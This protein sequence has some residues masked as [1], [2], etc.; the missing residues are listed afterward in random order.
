M[1]TG[2]PLPAGGE[3]GPSGD[4][5]DSCLGTRGGTKRQAQSNA[6]SPREEGGALTS[7]NKDRGQVSFPLPGSRPLHTG[8]VGAT[9]HPALLRARGLRAAGIQ[10]AWEPS[11]HLVR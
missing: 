7:E 1:S 8:A 4:S 10:P 9:L 3:K 6:R 5:G 11:T 2:G